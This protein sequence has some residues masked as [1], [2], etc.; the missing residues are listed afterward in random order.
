MFSVVLIEFLSK[1]KTIHPQHLAD[2]LPISPARCSVLLS[3]FLFQWFGVDS[4]DDLQHPGVAHA[5]TRS[6]PTHIL[7]LAM[8]LDPT[9]LAAHIHGLILST[10]RHSSCI[11][12]ISAMLASIN[13]Q[14]GYVFALDV[15]P[16]DQT[17]TELPVVYMLSSLPLFPP[18]AHPT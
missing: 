18:S 9:G 14:M 13:F 8:G 10:P 1:W 6:L 7:H 3:D 12:S 17:T 15:P 5:S 2:C 4:R 11:T 16:S